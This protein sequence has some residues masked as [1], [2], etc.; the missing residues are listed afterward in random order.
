MNVALP[1]RADQ[2]RGALVHPAVRAPGVEPLHGLPVLLDELPGEAT[3]I[4]ALEQAADEKRRVLTAHFA[5][6]RHLEGLLEELRL[7]EAREGI[8][9]ALLLLRRACPLVAI[10]ELGVLALPP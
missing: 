10:A 7:P 1:L 5:V 4:H 8:E 9:V 2:G 6:D 3:A